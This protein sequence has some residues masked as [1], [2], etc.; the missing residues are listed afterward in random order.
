MSHS[1]ARLSVLI[2]A[3]VLIAFL[4]GCGSSSAPQT[5]TPPP[6]VTITASPITATITAGQST[7]LSATVANASNTGITWSVQE[8][9]AGG[10][11]T[12]AG[13]Y[14][15]PTTAGNFHV[16]AT[17]QADGTKTAIVT[18]TVVLPVTVSVSPAT[19]ALS[20]GQS[21][22]FASTVK[23]ASDVTVA[24]SIQEST[25]CGAVT[26]AGVY[27]A[28]NTAATCHIVA[29]SNADKSKTAVAS[30]TVTAPNPSFTSTAPTAAAEGT[31][32][33]YNVVATDPANTAITY[34][35]TA[36]PAGAAINGSTLTWT[37]TSS[38]SRIDD[39]FTITATTA[40]GGSATQVFSVTPA[41]TVRGTKINTRFSD[42]G[43]AN[44]A[45][46]LTTTTIAA[47]IPNGTGGYSTIQGTG[48]VFGNFSVPGVPPGNYLLRVGADYLS[49]DKSVT[50]FGNF[51]GGRPDV[52]TTSSSGTSLQLSLTNLS[53]WVSGFDYLELVSPNAGAYSML[54]SSTTNGSTTVSATETW[55]RWL[56][57]SS[58][59]DQAYIAQLHST[60]TA[61]QNPSHIPYALHIFTRL[62][63]PSA[64]TIAN[65]GST[66]ISGAM[67]DVGTGASV[68][69][70]IK[71]S[72]FQQVGAAAN[73]NAVL[74]SNTVYLSGLPYGAK[75]G[76]TGGTVD[77]ITYNS[78]QGVIANDV[79]FGDIAY[80][81]SFP[82]W[83]PII[84]YSVAA[85]MQ[86]TPPG[87]ISA[88]TAYDVLSTTTTD[89]PSLTSPLQPL[90]GT[91]LSPT[92][93]GNDF[94]S[95]QSGVGS[96]PTISWAAP[97]FG[98]PSGY[99]VIVSIVNKNAAFITSGLPIYTTATSVTLPPGS[100]TS[101]LYYCV[102][103]EAIYRKGMDMS[104]SPLRQA[105]PSAVAPVLSGL[106]TP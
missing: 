57:D 49:T 9:A 38:Q 40:A 97:S 64:V 7:T 83:T 25:G 75:Y 72:A 104:V 88:T 1:P 67:T 103:L 52:I 63:G 102:R 106:I 80:G 24:W 90:I 100:L 21:Q 73:P 29:T 13:V 33:T 93:N 53:P 31:V 66:A 5:N 58:K 91:V 46:D 19:V 74:D 50:D 71:G 79:D 15:A 37:P 69:L 51:V 32:Y 82:T 14:T 85:W 6:A 99:R 43:E 56:L 94:F 48:D 59:G 35:L 4:T 89:L 41:G 10:S 77:F 20:V 61:V 16:I 68:R 42:A 22:T 78:D 8:G 3:V 30:V 86:Y 60:S 105:L 98:T 28:P 95:D 18:I 27:T 65:G 47:L 55:R 44:Q 54:G 39:S 62:L 81:D 26:T 2:S 87:A 17:S 76:W 12:S 36:G 92:I 84:D 96:S 34:S 11:V 101:G 45:V 70:N 23:N